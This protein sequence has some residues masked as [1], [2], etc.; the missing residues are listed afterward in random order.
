MDT[1]AFP[2]GDISTRGLVAWA[3]C[4][5]S[6]ACDLLT[7]IKVNTP[8]DDMQCLKSR[9]GFNALILRI[10]VRSNVLFTVYF[11]IFLQYLFHE[12]A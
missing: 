11:A 4:D 3:S 8:L 9:I 2:D 1:G 6:R 5:I 7:V 10:N 12:I